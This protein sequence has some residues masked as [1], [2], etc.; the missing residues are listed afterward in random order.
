MNRST[1]AAFGAG[2]LA[3]AG[4]LALIASG[5][6][7]HDTDDAEHGHAAMEMDPDEMMAAYMALG[8][9]GEHHQE[10]MKSVGEWDAVT[11]FVM[12]PTNPDERT[13]EK[14]SCTVVPI[15]GGRFVK[16]RFASSMMGMPFEGLSFSG[17]DNGREMFASTWMDTVS[18]SITYMEGDMNDDGDLVMKGMAYAPGAGEYM[19]KMVYKWDDSDHWT[20]VFYDQMPD[21][22]W[23]NSGEIRYT[24]R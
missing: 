17:Y 1:I 8:Q 10:L 4:A 24:R 23:F 7:G 19:M 11:A 5:P 21:G 9:P 14:G 20:Q 22:S 6:G 13:I 15:M 3:A 16:A 2:A 18:T 12:D